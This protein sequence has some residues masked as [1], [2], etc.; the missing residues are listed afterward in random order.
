MNR[1]L[2]V[3]VI[4]AMADTRTRTSELD[5]SAFEDLDV[6]HR[7]AV[8][9]FSRDNVRELVN[10][11]GTNW[12]EEEGRIRLEALVDTASLFFTPALCV[13]CAV[14][15]GGVTTYM[16]PATTMSLQ[17]SDA[18]RRTLKSKNQFYL[19]QPACAA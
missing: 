17:P 19:S 4:L 6:A 16:R 14:F 9:E 12:K 5:L 7:V 8:L 2:R 1:H 10:R 3:T 18:S 13:L 11:T 15:R